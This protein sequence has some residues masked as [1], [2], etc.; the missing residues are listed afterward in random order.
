[1]AANDISKVMAEFLRLLAGEVESNQ[2]LAKRLSVPFTE[3]INQ[4]PDK[5]PVSPRIP[6]QKTEKAIVPEGFDPFAIY[7]EQGSVGLLAALSDKD[8]AIL[9]AILSHF[10]LD[11]TRSYTRWR[12]QERLAEFIV[13]RVKAMS[14]KGSA[15][16]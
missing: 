7:Y 6:K 12:K 8:P 1:M 4:L 15:F 10:A 16:R 2:A 13:Q 14:T 3:Y 9:K 11:P 5:A